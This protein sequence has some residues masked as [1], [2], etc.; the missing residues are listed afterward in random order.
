MMWY[1][2]MSLVGTRSF[3]SW[4]KV[5]L[6]RW[7]SAKTSTRGGWSP[8]RSSRTWRSTGRRPN[9]R[10]TCWT[11]WPNMIPRWMARKKCQLEGLGKFGL[12]LQG[13]NL[14]VLMYD[15]FDY[16][17]HQ[18]IAF[19]LLGWFRKI[20]N[21]NSLSTKIFLGQSV[22]DFLKD[23]NY[24]PYPVEQVHMAFV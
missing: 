21:W 12:N 6:G 3:L 16:H 23:N 1:D 7:W 20:W 10:S 4:E 14:C 8:S 5:L 17:G 9:W 19:E 13:A 22:F 24:N 2:M 11:N 15:C 18:C